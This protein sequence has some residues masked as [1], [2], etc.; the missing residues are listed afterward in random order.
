[1]K[2]TK[3]YFQQNNNNYFDLYDITNVKEVYY[4]NKESKI[5][6]TAREYEIEKIGYL[7]SFFWS[8]LFSSEFSNMEF[9]TILDKNE[10]FYLILGS[11]STEDLIE[12]NTWYLLDWF[13]YNENINYLRLRE[14]NVLNRIAKSKFEGKDF[15]RDC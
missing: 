12:L 15:I 3:V 11:I 13:N 1:M 4:F 9:G 14:N 5:Y 6:I 8:S 10:Y 2:K 7:I